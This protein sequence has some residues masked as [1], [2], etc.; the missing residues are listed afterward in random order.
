MKIA[1]Y[2][3][4]YNPIHIGHTAL[5]KHLIDHKVVDEVWFVVS[6]CNPLK[7]QKNLL[8]EYL[9]LDMVM[10]A[11]QN[12]NN[13]KVSDVE[14]TMP[15]P[16]YTFDTLSKLEVDFPEHEFS[17]IIGSDNAVVFDK[18]KNY[19]EILQKYDVF[20]YPRKGY[21]FADVSDIYPQMRLLNTPLYDI[22]STEIRQAIAQKKDVTNWLHPSV[23]EFIIENKLYQ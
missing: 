6:P 9:R 10:L 7:D 15:I 4:S 11:I 5:A 1:L 3:G 20:V 12:Q 22:S 19:K 17:L 13:F 18:W 23:Y 14:F 2:S 21:D 8:D 16:S